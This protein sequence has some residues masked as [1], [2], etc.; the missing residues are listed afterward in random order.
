MKTGYCF[1]TILISGLCFAGFPSHAGENPKTDLAKYILNSVMSS[2]GVEM[3]IGFNTRAEPANTSEYFPE[4]AF[5]M[6]KGFAFVYQPKE[7]YFGRLALYD[8]EN[9][10]VAKSALGARY[11]LDE[12]LRWDT[13]KMSGKRPAPFGVQENWDFFRIRLPSVS[14]LFNIKKPGVYRLVLELQVFLR[15]DAKGEVVRFPP[16]EIAI[17]QPVTSKPTAKVGGLTNAPPAK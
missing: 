16:L 9:R 11:K 7:E 5:R 3:G 8:E 15:R 4:L 1:E 14:Q 6:R 12:G 13:A 2:N 10:P 17:I